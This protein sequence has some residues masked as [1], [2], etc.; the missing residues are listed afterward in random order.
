MATSIPDGGEVV[1]GLRITLITMIVIQAIDWLATI[2]Y[3]ATGHLAV[4]RVPTAAIMPVLFIGGLLWFWPRGA[5]RSGSPD[6]GA[7]P[8]GRR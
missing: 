6:P 2:G 1:R 4:R 7:V 5:G 8:A 3:L